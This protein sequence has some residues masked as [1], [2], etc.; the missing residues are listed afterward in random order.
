MRA[1]LLL[2]V[3]FAGALATEVLSLVDPSIDPPSID[4]PE[5]HATSRWLL[6]IEL[7][8]SILLC[9]GSL[10]WAVVRWPKYTGW[11]KTN[12]TYAYQ[13]THPLSGTPFHPF[14]AGRIPPGDASSCYY[15]A[16]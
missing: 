13:H 12:E 3:V 15:E 6:L 5:I 16:G 7:L 11:V 8:V 2:G 10:G 4:S 9:F 14:T 1:V